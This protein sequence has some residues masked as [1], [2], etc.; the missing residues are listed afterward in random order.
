MK[1]TFFFSNA[2]EIKTKEAIIQ[3]AK[4][5]CVCGVFL[6]GQLGKGFF[7]QPKGNPALLQ[8]YNQPFACNA[9]GQKQCMN[10]CLEVVS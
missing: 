8:E 10:K 9:I 6:S 3:K 4:V 5:P 7:A 2:Q 1:C